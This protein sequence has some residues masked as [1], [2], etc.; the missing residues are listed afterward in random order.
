MVRNPKAQPA[1]FT[2]SPCIALEIP[3]DISVDWT[4]SARLVWGRRNPRAFAKDGAQTN[5][6]AGSDP[7]EQLHP[8]AFSVATVA[9]RS[10]CA[11]WELDLPPHQLAIYD[12]DCIPS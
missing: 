7:P 6:A 9:A 12:V 4:C 3:A 5:D 1:P 8:L 11:G 10:V 2:V